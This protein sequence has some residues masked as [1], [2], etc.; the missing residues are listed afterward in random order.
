MPEDVVDI[1]VTTP[2]VFSKLLTNSKLSVSDSLCSMHL[3]A[4]FNITVPF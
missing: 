1:L 2:G 4:H 3:L